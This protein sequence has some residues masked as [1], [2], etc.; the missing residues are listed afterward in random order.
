MKKFAPTAI[1]IV[2]QETGERHP[3][4]KS[5][6]I[7]VFETIPSQYPTTFHNDFMF[8]GEQVF[9]TVDGMVHSFIVEKPLTTTVERTICQSDL[10]EARVQISAIRLAAGQYAEAIMEP[11]GV[12]RFEAMARLVQRLEQEIADGEKALAEQAE[13]NTVTRI[14]VAP[15]GQSRR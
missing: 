10:D 4:R 5:D 14:T 1:V 9:A 3:G 2:D 12:Q 15:V 11:G 8:E 13:R 6:D 7:W